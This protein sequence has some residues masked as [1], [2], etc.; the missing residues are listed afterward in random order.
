MSADY[1]DWTI[2]FVRGYGEE[3]WLTVPGD[4][5]ATVTLATLHRFEIS[6]GSRVSTGQDVLPVTPGQPATDGQ[7]DDWLQPTSAPPAPAPLPGQAA[8]PEDTHPLTQDAPWN[9]PIH[10]D[11]TV[12][13]DGTMLTVRFQGPDADQTWHG[14]AAGIVPGDGPHEPGLLQVVAWELE[15]GA[16]TRR[17]S[18]VHP[19]LTSTL[20]DDPYQGL[21]PRQRERWQLFDQAAAAGRTTADLPAELLDPEDVFQFPPLPGRRGAVITV[22]SLTQMPGGKTSIQ[23]KPAIGGETTLY[24]PPAGPFHTRIPARHPSLAPASAPPPGHTAE[25]ADSKPRT[26]GRPGP[27]GTDAGELPSGTRP[28]TGHQ[29]WNGPGRP[30]RLVYADGTRLTVRVPRSPDPPAL[31]SGTRAAVAAGVSPAADGGLMQVVR[32]EDGGGYAVAH[33][34]VTWP[35]G[36]DPYQGLDE[37]RR[38]RWQSFDAAEA[39]PHHK[40]GDP[41]NLPSSLTEPGDHVILYVQTK[42]RIAEVDRLQPVAG[43]S[44]RREIVFKGRQRPLEASDGLIIPVQIPRLHPT[45]AAAITAITRPP[46]PATAPAPAGQH[47]GRRARPTD[48]HRYTRLIHSQ[49]EKLQASIAS[50]DRDQV[51]AACRDAV[52]AW[53]R[54][55]N[56]WP[57]DANQWQAALDQ[58]LPDFSDVDFAVDPRLILEDLAP[59]PAPGDLDEPGDADEPDA[60][61]D[62]GQLSETSG[63]GPASPGAVP[64]TTPAPAP[65]AAAD[66][67]EPAPITNSDVAAAWRHIAADSSGQTW[68]AAEFIAHGTAPAPGVVH[69]PDNPQDTT[70]WDGDGLRRT[71]TSGQPPRDGTLTW[72]QAARWINAGMTSGDLRILLQASRVVRFCDAWL[73]RV[74]GTA[75]DDE[76]AAFYDAGRGATVI[77]QDCISRVTAAAAQAHGPDAPVPAAPASADSY[78]REKVTTTAEQAR[79]LAAIS[80]LSDFAHQAARRVNRSTPDQP[81][82][83]AATADVTSPGAPAGHTAAETPAGPAMPT[84]GGQPE[85]TTPA[86]ITN[87]DVA[88]AWLHITASSSAAAW[89]VAEFVTHGTA[90]GPGSLTGPDD[91]QDTTAWDRHGLRRTVTSGQPPRDGTLTWDQATRWINA[92]MT[93]GDLQILLHAGR[94]IAFCNAW[95]EQVRGT[96]NQE[97]AFDDA[98][99]G[100]A[101]IVR[102]CIARVTAAAAQAHQPDAPAATGLPDADGYRRQEI[103]TTPGQDETLAAISQLSTLAHQATRQITGTGPLTTAQIRAAIKQVIGDSLPDYV[104]AATGPQPMRDL[105]T[106]I[107]SGH[108]NQAQAFTTGEDPASGQQATHGQVQVTERRLII[109][110]RGGGPQH[111]IAWEELP[112]WILGALDATQRAELIAAAR[113]AVRDP[114]AATAEPARQVIDHAWA[115]I[116]AAPPPADADIASA[117]TRYSTRQAPQDDLFATAGTILPP[118]GAGIADA[119]PG[120]R[121][122]HPAGATAEP[123]E[124]ASPD[125][126]HLPE[127]LVNTAVWAVPDDIPAIPAGWMIV[128]AARPLRGADGRGWA[129]SSLLGIYYAAAPARPPHWAGPTPAPTASPSSA[130]TTSQPAS[131]ST[132]PA[133]DSAHRRKQ[134]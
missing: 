74:R 69:G 2:A 108:R 87:S 101:A 83:T 120:D 134:A 123:A 23:G 110:R 47:A 30:E 39:S 126:G 88:A 97:T 85:R 14:T 118:A 93:P 53:N 78:R 58:F 16:E 22:E 15:T 8:R 41:A 57:P 95:L 111:A 84:S 59:E 75:D 100:A 86:P 48:V 65:A 112:P 79:D 67:A 124:P 51:V 82:T 66:P 68:P 1:R 42:P 37:R 117:R 129:G 28:L 116:L 107:S 133:A 98:G 80:E 61:F 60:L 18:I 38:R 35:A 31:L 119:Q 103:T 109:S 91:P 70:A 21:D 71:V 6:R 128:N 113:Q 7:L 46:A 49:R 130:T 25:P 3:V 27:A 90:P 10:P 24:S 114:A 105:A 63:S 43:E 12:Y 92:G 13:Q 102:D 50:G 127:V 99:Q 73:E 32:W 121:A 33:P 89:S 55:G 122:A 44:G 94:V 36:T 19:V 72:D 45:L 125:D 52:I 76:A 29:P 9:G 106:R 17:Y 96:G 26:P 77:V 11:L 115:T 132:W 56:I 54:P 81:D 64:G 34:A 4:Q 62:L 5:P 20:T 131:P 104:R 40:D